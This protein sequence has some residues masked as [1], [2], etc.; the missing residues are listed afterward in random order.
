MIGGFGNGDGVSFTPVRS[1]RPCH[2]E[3]KLIGADGSEPRP[4]L[5]VK[6][7]LRDA[8]HHLELD[9]LQQSIVEIGFPAKQLFAQG[10]QSEDGAN[11]QPAAQRDGDGRNVRPAQGALE[12]LTG[13]V[14]KIRPFR[15]VL[16]RIDEEPLLAVEVD[17]REFL[18]D[19]VGDLAGLAYESTSI[20][21]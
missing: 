8:A 18:I 12:D 17:V 19:Q 7:Q 6:R 5:D 1:W 2:G 16:Q 9:D 13:L 20:L 21:K 14:F 10:R 15:L 11:T 3:A 4:V